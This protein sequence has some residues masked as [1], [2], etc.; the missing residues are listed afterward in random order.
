M[1]YYAGFIWKNRQLATNNRFKQ[2]L[3]L[4]IKRLPANNVFKRNNLFISLFINFFINLFINCHTSVNKFMG[5]ADEIIR[6]IFNVIE[7]LM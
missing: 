7:H 5:I 1:A 6:R 4:Y 3:L 2:A